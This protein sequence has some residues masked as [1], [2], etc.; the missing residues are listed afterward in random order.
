MFLREKRK[1]ISIECRFNE[2]ERAIRWLSELENAG[3]S[4][5]ERRS[6]YIWLHGL[7]KVTSE[8]KKATGTGRLFYNIDCFLMFERALSRKHHGNLWISF[9]T[10]LY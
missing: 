1:N 7:Y 4:F 8:I 5:V 3:A 10:S 2:K 9:V 6:M